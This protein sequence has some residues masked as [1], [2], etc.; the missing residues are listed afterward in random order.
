MMD[1]LLFLFLCVSAYYF[2]GLFIVFKKAPNLIMFPDVW[3]ILAIVW[4]IVFIVRDKGE[5]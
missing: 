1:G 2:V 5:P 3:A 4:P